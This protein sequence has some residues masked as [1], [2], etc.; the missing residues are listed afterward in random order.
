M[1]IPLLIAAGVSAYS[2]YKQGKAADNTAGQ[3]EKLAGQ[4]SSLAKEIMGYGQQQYGMGAPAM[5]QAMKYYTTLATGNRG[6]I[7][8]ALAPQRN[9]IADSASGIEQGLDNHLAPGPTRD[10][11]IADLYR[12]KAGQLGMLPINA[13]QNAMG[14]LATQGQQSVGN[15]ASFFGQSSGALN[16]AG[17][18]FDIAGQN[19]ANAAGAYGQMGNDLGKLGGGV[20]DWY[21]N[22]G[23]VAG[24]SPTGPYASG[25]KF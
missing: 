24:N 10:R 14:Q 25:Y 12:Q 6:A 17:N 18:M 16:S 8:T 22:R 21:K 5:Q 7:D 11:A 1:P 15:A 2:A 13:R 3:Q 4:Q 23:G 19:R 9:Q 20:W